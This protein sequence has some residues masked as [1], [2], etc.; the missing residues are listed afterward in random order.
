MS[1][2]VATLAL[3][4][5]CA[6]AMPAPTGVTAACVTDNGIVI[7]DPVPPGYCDEIQGVED[8]VFEAFR[9]VVPYDARFGSSKARVKGWAVV[10][11]D[12]LVWSNAGGGNVL[13][14]TDC[15]NRVIYV[16]NNRPATSPFGHEL[17]H[18]IQN[19]Q[20]TEPWVLNGNAQDY[21][22]SNWVPIYTALE[23]AKLQ[24]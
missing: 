2:K 15:D 12:A 14:Q 5:S 9:S 10:V 22:H 17:A 24:K 19:C 18:A 3:L 1:A 6:G 21:Y 20:P 16:N 8:R 13:G 23:K 11:V 7:L 4:C